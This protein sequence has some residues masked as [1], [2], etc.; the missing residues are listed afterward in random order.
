MAI[1]DFF[2]SFLIFLAIVLIAY[3][4]YY[5]FQGSKQELG[6]EQLKP[7][8]SQPQVVRLEN[9]LLSKEPWS[10]KS[11]IKEFNLT[12]E[13]IKDIGQIQTQPDKKEGLKS[14]F[15]YLLEVW[16]L[17][18][19]E[20]EII[21][22]ALL[23]LASIAVG[24]YLWA[25]MLRW[26]PPEVWKS[27]EHSR[28]AS[29]PDLILLA[30]SFVCVGVAAL[31]LS[32]FSAC[33]GVVY[34]LRR[35][36]YPSTIAACF[37]IVLS[38]VWALWIFQWMDGWI[39]V[40]Q[41]LERLPKKNDR[42]SP[43][44]RALSE[45]LYFA[46]KLGTIGILPALILGRGLLAACRDSISVVKSKFIEAAKLRV[47]YSFLCW[48]VGV[49][50]YVGTIFFFIWGHF[51]PPG[52][53]IY[54][55]V[56][57]FYFWA[58]IPLLAAVAIIEL[59]LR[60]AYIVGSCELYAQ[61]LTEHNNKITLPQPPSKGVSAFVFFAV[62]CLLIAIVFLYRGPLGINAALSIPYN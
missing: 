41:I 39:T 7:I 37:R 30:W 12:K 47:G 3:A 43:A 13:S 11:I 57:T 20:K 51:I 15:G 34:F 19:R 42:E 4:I 23:Q 60:P 29:L 54:G 21:T 36:G 52:A 26:I 61:Y 58:G 24:Y 6:P 17:T 48:I 40:N 33:I 55:F 14:Y 49:T 59:F 31:P 56:Y 2:I 53:K 22:F 45:A 9:T 44:Q 35:Q 46:W 50:A 28:H 62:L 38:E 16:N 5:V 32:I 25:Q 27:A 18:L 1:F 10:V 8:L